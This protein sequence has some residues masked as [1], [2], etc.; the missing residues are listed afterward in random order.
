[1]N[2]VFSILV[3]MISCLGCQGQ[4]NLRQ[5][6]SAPAQSQSIARETDNLV[7]FACSEGGSE[8]NIVRQFSEFLIG[9]DYPSIRSKLFSANPGEKYLA[10]VVCQ[11]LY[12]K[13][14]IELSKKE[15]K[16]I[17]SNKSSKDVVSICSGCTDWNK[18]TI[19]ELFKSDRNFLK[20]RTEQWLKEMIK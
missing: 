18:L 15:L 14:F 8:S 2:K 11:R 13:Q 12:Q 20:D 19:Q 5:K 16:Q 9:K 4:K 17:K 7:G 6:K 3:I 10:T 1:M